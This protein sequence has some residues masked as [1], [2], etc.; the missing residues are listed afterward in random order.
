MKVEQV[1]YESTSKRTFFLNCRRKCSNQCFP[2][3]FVLNAVCD[4]NMS[5]Q[6]SVKSEQQ[7]PEGAVYCRFK[8]HTLLQKIQPPMS[9]LLVTAGRKYFLLTG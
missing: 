9:K 5:I 2:C 3:V 1:S 6:V 7:S 8:N 4:T